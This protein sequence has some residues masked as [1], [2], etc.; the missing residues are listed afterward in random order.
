M[1]TFTFS[2][3]T[4][5]TVTTADLPVWV[6]GEPEY[7]SPFSKYLPVTIPTKGAFISVFCSIKST[8]VFV[9]SYCVFN[10]SYCCCFALPDFSNV[11]SLE[12][13]FVRLPVSYT[14]LRA[15]ETRHDLVCR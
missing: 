5:I 9:T 12:R 2:G 6:V 3:L 4:C 11:S 8:F 7:I 13:S 15:H 1:L 14:H 10:W